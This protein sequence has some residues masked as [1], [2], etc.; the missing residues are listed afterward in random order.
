MIKSFQI[1][2]FFHATL[3]KRQP[4]AVSASGVLLVAAGGL[5]DTVLL[6]LVL[7]RFAELAGAGDA[8]TV[9]IRRESKKMD[10]LFPDNVNVLAV[11]FARF[12][13]NL[14]YRWNISR[15]LYNNN[16][17]LVVSVDFLRHPYL[18]EAMI[19]ACRAPESMA[20]IP[21]PWPKYDRQLRHNQSIFNRLF[22][23]GP[24]H[25][26]KVVRWARFADWLTGRTRPPPMVYLPSEKAATETDREGGP[27]V[28]QPFSA[29]GAKQLPA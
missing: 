16:Y 26:D 9:L 21:R 24:I 5:G 23:S 2:D 25:M 13:S 29:V 15:T 4:R 6:S 20:M 7:N 10:F 28:I 8:V 11:D 17:R 18:D 27:V 19:R 1:L 3:R 14:A 12:H 22:D